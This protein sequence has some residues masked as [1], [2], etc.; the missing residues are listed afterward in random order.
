MV[1]LHLRGRAEDRAGGAGDELVQNS[2]A[3]GASNWGGY[4]EPTSNMTVNTSDLTPLAGQTLSWAFVTADANTGAGAWEESFADIA[5]VQPDGSVITLYNNQIGLTYSGASASGVSSQNFSTRMLWDYSVPNITTHYFLDDH[6]CGTFDYES[7][8]TGAKLTW[9]IGGKRFPIGSFR[10]SS[11]SDN[12]FFPG[13]SLNVA[14][15]INVAQKKRRGRL[16]P[17][18]PWLSSPH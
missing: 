3:F 7:G 10:G 1:G 15:N 2:Q 6:L 9:R 17:T 16:S 8:A 18:A 11:N 13:W 5:V 14:R 4:C 12:Q